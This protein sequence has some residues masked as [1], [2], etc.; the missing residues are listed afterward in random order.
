MYNTRYTSTELTE[1]QRL[2]LQELFNT[3]NPKPR[4]RAERRKQEK[5]NRN[6]RN[7]Q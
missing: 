1:E 2:K 3:E 4:N 7:K 5:Q 6:R